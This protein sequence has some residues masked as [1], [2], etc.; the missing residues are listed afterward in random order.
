MDENELKTRLQHDAELLS[1]VFDEELFERIRNEILK[2]SVPVRA[3][4]PHHF[5]LQ[6]AV[7]ICSSVLIGIGIWSLM[8]PHS[9]TDPNAFAQKEGNVYQSDPRMNITPSQVSLS[10]NTAS[11]PAPPQAQSSV[12]DVPNGTLFD[13]PVPKPQS[14][15]ELSLVLIPGHGLVR[16]NHRPEARPDEKEENTME[17]GSGL[18]FLD[19]ASKVVRVPVGWILEEE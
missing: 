5:V 18:K 19:E 15:E 12:F 10:P 17:D 2:Q 14:L 6:Y 4:R 16:M 13:L 7:L 11:V 3:S 1:K 8:R 9:Q